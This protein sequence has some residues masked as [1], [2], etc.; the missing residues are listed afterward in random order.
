MVEPTFH[1]LEITAQLV[2]LATG[3]RIT[4]GGE[5]NIPDHGGAVVAI[6]H[7]SYVDFLPAALAMRVSWRSIS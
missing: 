3:T 5:E 1:T 2:V 4:Y 6:N 7:T